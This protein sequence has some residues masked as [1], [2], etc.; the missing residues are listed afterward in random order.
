M[1]AP[2]NMRPLATA[3]YRQM[4]TEQLRAAIASGELA[5]GERLNE[6]AVAKQLGVSPTPVREAFRDLE[7]AGLIEVVPYRGARVRPLTERDLSEI[8]SLRAHLEQMGIRLAY[9]RLTE[10]D[11]EELAGLIREME[12]CARNDDP[13]GVVRHDVAFHRLIM[14]RSDHSLLLKTWEQIHPSRWTYVTVRVLANR[15]PLYIAQ[16]HWPLLEALRGPSPELA[17]DA[18]AK[19]IELVGDEAMQVLRGQPGEENH[20]P[21]DKPDPSGASATTEAQ[22]EH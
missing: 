8:Y 21:T 11:F 1:N 19:H 18:A 6:V 13:S 20:A 15:G 12:T 10:S 3:S 22:G 16:R 7:Q 17:V 9:S 4:V 14:D 5:A 2:T